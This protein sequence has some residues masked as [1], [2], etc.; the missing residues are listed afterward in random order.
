MWGRAT[1]LVM[2]NGGVLLQVY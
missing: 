2:D 1:G